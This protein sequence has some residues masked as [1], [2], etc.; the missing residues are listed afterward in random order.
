MKSIIDQGVGRVLRFNK[1]VRGILVL[2]LLM[3]VVV[4]HAREMVSVAKPQINIRA[5][6]GLQHDR[7]WVILQDYPLQVTAHRGK[8]L[9][10]RDF[11]NDGGWVYAPLVGKKPHVIVKA[12]VANVRST[13]STRGR[14]LGKAEY[15]DVLRT[16]EHRNGWVKVRR[17]S[18]LTGWIARRL[19][20]G[21]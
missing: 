15:G 6:A 9:K 2:C 16:L 17:D 10:V 3:P 8:W 4:L 12:S 20:W 7:L 14:I 11:E 13:A 1:Y 21:W 5:G 18:G 19:L